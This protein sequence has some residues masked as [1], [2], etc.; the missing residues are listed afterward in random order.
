[1]QTDIVGWFGAVRLCL[2]FAAP[3]IIT[4][5]FPSYFV[6]P[7]SV[8]NAVVSLPKRFG[9][10]KDAERVDSTEKVVILLA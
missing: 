5:V 4:L 3:M 2:I 6:L 9:W 8:Q 7:E 10:P 1:M